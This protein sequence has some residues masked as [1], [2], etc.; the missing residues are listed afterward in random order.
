[1]TKTYLAHNLDDLA[2]VEEQ[3]KREGGFIPE[4]RYL[5]DSATMEITAYFPD[6]PELPNPQP[7]ES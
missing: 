6:Q 4:F 2:N 3:V 5:P 1:M 7:K